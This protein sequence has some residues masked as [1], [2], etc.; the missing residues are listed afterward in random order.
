MRAS[1]F[2]DDK[3]QSCLP[4]NNQQ[5]FLRTA[6][7]SQGHKTLRVKTCCMLDPLKLWRE[8]PI[9]V[10]LILWNN[11]GGPLS[12]DGRNGWCDMYN[13]FAQVCWETPFCSSGKL[14]ISFSFYTRS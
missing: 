2:L 6:H 5:V 1:F 8:I 9:S 3:V 7:K 13:I 11:T 10:G 4:Q 12:F 14:I